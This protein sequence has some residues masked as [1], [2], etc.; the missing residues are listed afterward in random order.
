M[1]QI[2]TDRY[3]GDLCAICKEKLEAVCIKCNVNNCKECESV[4]GRCG[5][6][7]HEHC[8]EYWL[9]NR[10]VCP[11]DNKKWHV[12]SENYG[13]KS[14]RHLCYKKIGMDINLTLQAIIAGETVVT[15]SDWDEIQKYVEKPS[16]LYT[17]KKPESISKAAIRVLEIQFKT[18][19]S[20]SSNNT[21]N[22]K[23]S[24]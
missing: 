13:P 15:D 11:L 17:F 2:V 9:K 8:I 1:S 24:K 7:Y 20:P 16:R 3:K 18:P 21:Q 22:Q 10:I 23:E 4:M 19:S 6:A 5:H 14:L 12:F